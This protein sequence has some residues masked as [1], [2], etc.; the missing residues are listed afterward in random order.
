M[1]AILFFI[2]LLVSGGL[3]GSGTF[4][5]K[6]E[7]QQAESQIQLHVFI[8]VCTM[9]HWEEVLSRQLSRIFASGLYAECKSISL[10]VLG[11]GDMKRFLR[12]YRKIKVLFQD[13]EVKLYE[14]PTLLRLHALCSAKG[15][16]ACVLYL[17][18][19]GVSHPPDRNPVTDW[20]KFMEY[21]TIDSWR[22]CV[23]V[24]TEERFDIC[25]VNWGE[26]PSPHFSG[27]FWWARGDYVRTLPA[28]IGPGYVDPEMW[29][30]QNS[31]N[32]KCLYQ[33]HRDHYKECYPESEYRGRFMR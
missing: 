30:G 23:R 22:D 31:P 2:C 24:L 15:E 28:Y 26:R 10:G 16:K 9:G 25:G 20:T 1:K 5:D 19:K 18:T 3:F 6:E 14:R 32:F 33:S 17:H 27:N 4:Y 12:E 11:Q 7:I 8:H 29:I 13:P 21:F